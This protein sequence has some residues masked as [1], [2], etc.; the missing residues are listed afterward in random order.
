MN[1]YTLHAIVRT[2][3]FSKNAH[4]LVFKRGY[5]R[6]RPG[7]QI[8][9]LDIGKYYIASGIQEPWAR[10][11]IDDVHIPSPNIRIAK[12]ITNLYPTLVGANP[13]DTVFIAGDLGIGPCLSFCGT[14]PSDKFAKIIYKHSGEGVNQLWLDA[15]QDTIHCEDLSIALSEIPIDNKYN[16]Y[17]CCDVLDEN[18]MAKN[19][20]L[21]HGISDRVIFCKV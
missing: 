8:D 7:D 15:N 19:Y 21:N 11:L 10:V 9:I 18:T 6:Y 5:N 13:K 12:D 16:Y 14:F 20:L 3:T 17:I 1:D 4:E 2:K